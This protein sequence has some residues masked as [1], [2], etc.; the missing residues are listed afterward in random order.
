MVVVTGASRGLGNAIAKRLRSNGVEVVGIARSIEH[1]NYECVQCDVSDYLSV[2]SAAKTVKKMGRQI[3]AVV[4][5][6]GIAS[7]NLA[8]MSDQ[9]TTQNIIQTNLL[10]TIFCCQLFAPI[11]LR[12]NR[13]CFINFSTIAVPLALKG[14]SIYVASKAGVEAFSRTFAREVADFNLRVNCISPGPINTDLVEGLDADQINK[15]ASQQIIQKQ[16]MQ[17]DVCD[18]V[19]LLL[20]PRASSISGQVIHVGGV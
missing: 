8:L 15:V 19:E 2:K 17:S 14:E 6:A 10:G 12:Q 5:A 9:N 11:M 18:L 3:S 1:L 13:G 4:N 20:D 7:M 16:F